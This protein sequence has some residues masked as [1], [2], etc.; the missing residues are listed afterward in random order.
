MSLQKLSLQPKQ[1]STSYSKKQIDRA[2]KTFISRDVAKEKDIYDI[3]IE[4]IVKEYYNFM[5][6]QTEE[7]WEQPQ[8]SKNKIDKAGKILG[9]KN[10]SQEETEQALT[11]LNN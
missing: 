10:V 11:I 7:F 2:G 8:Y 4:N 1:P 5:I 3:I 9:N 6:N